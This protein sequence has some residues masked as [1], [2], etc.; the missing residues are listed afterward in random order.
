MNN[1]IGFISCMQNSVIGD[2][3][4]ALT[5]YSLLATLIIFILI[6]VLKNQFSKNSGASNQQVKGGIQ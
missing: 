3:V 4:I 1:T 2:I 5:I 6:W